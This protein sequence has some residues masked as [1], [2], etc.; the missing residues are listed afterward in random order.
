MPTILPPGRLA[1]A[2]TALTALMC[3][4]SAL[5]QAIP[6]IAAERL[7]ARNPRLITDETKALSGDVL[8]PLTPNV[9]LA[10]ESDNELDSDPFTA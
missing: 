3:D 4:A 1:A 6:T 8:I 10:C 5:E 9:I 7:G 2:L